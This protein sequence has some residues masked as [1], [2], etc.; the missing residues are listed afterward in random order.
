MGSVLLAAVA[1]TG[2]V[3]SAS[4]HRRRPGCGRSCRQLGGL[5]GTE[6]ACLQ[7]AYYIGSANASDSK[8]LKMRI[9][10]EYPAT[11]DLML[12]VVTSEQGV[13]P[14]HGWSVNSSST[15]TTGGQTQTVQIFY[16]FAANR[17]SSSFTFTSSTPQPISGAL[18][19]AMGVSRRQPFDYRSGTATI[20]PPS[21]SVTAP[22][23]T[24][25]SGHS[26]LLFVGTAGRKVSWTAPGGM[27]PLYLDSFATPSAN[28]LGIATERWR[29]AAATGNRKA[30]ISASS[31]AYGELI[32]LHYPSPITCPK[33]KVLS[34]Q[35]QPNRRGLLFVKMRCN[36]TARCR[37]AFEGVDLEDHFPVPKVAASDFTIPAGETRSVPIAMT[38]AGSKALRRRG[39]LKFD[40]YIWAYTSARQIVVAGEARSTIRAPRG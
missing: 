37:G 35:F 39:K 28:R 38:R 21:R 2:A 26:L 25:T 20:G 29:P 9:R 16:R 7:D 13:K 4:S 5:G 23:I 24:A 32:A 22:S 34:H 10:A 33:V 15:G 27:K 11:G 17:T 18:I 14:P 8:L 19:A 3:A 12:A 1:L 31:P 30:T 40:I 6:G 36:W